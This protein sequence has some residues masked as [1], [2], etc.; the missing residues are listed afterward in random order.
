M[1]PTTRGGARKGAG[2][3]PKDGAIGLK[4]V[5]ITIDQ[6][7]VLTLRTLGGGDLSLGIRRAAGVVGTTTKSS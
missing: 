6:S 4:R 3:R 1:T 7:S 2:R 5:L